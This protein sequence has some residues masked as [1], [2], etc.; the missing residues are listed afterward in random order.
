MDEVDL[1]DMGNRTLNLDLLLGGAKSC[2]ESF[3]NID[4]LRTQMHLC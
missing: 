2:V 1:E 3:T 4:Y